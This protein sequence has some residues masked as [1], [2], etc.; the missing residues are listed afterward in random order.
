MHRF[1]AG[2]AL[3]ALILGIVVHVSRG[4]VATADVKAKQV[5]QGDVI[6]AD[7][8]VDPAP[9]LDGVVYLHVGP[10]GGADQLVLSCGLPKAVTKCE[11]SGR[12]PLDA[13]LGKWTIMKISFQPSAPSAEKELSRNGDLSFQVDPHG[14]VVL[15]DSATVSGIK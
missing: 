13:K 11:A 10:D 7:V 1:L 2:V 4:Q 6:D 5:R 3:G 8:S 12:M 9:S 14:D 15:P